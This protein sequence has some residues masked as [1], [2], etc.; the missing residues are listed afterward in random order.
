MLEHPVYP[1]QSGSSQNASD[2]GSHRSGFHLLLDTQRGHEHVV[3]Q[4]N[5][6]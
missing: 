5:F 6:T 4:P 1:F 2:D 3:S